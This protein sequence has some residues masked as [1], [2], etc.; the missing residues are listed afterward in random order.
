MS[1]RDSSGKP[2]ADGHVRK[3][4]DLERIAPR[5]T[6]D[7]GHLLDCQQCGASPPATANR[8]NYS[9]AIAGTFTVPVFSHRSWRSWRSGF[10]RSTGFAT[11]VA[12][13]IVND[14]LDE[15]SW[16]NNN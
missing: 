10:R 4:E 3:R 1:G 7:R 8:V 5:G 9:N 2:T 16:H 12:G 14:L 13:S 11:G 6:N 15:H